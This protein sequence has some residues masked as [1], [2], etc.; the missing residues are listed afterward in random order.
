MTARGIRNKL[1]D[2]PGEV[3]VDIPELKGKY[4][5]SCFGRVKSI[6]HI[7]ANAGSGRVIP[8][9]LVKLQINTGGYFCFVR[10]IDTAFGKKPKMFRV[11]IL[12][13]KLFVPNPENKLQVDH[14]DGDKLNNNFLN[15]RWASPKEN[16]NNPKTSWKTKGNNHPNKGKSLRKGLP[17]HRAVLC[18][19]DGIVYPTIKAAHEA[20]GISFQHFR[21]HLVKGE[22]IRGKF[23]IYIED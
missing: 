13:A 15:L 10:N 1:T 7:V 5:V 20:A 2:I 21:K 11:H 8:E 12:V 3:W 19:T 17:N 23:Y 9:H 22:E 14:I 6:E 4:Q 16:S 18:I